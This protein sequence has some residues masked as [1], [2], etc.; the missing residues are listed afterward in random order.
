M[1]VEVKTSGAS[2]RIVHRV[3][4][5]YIDLSPSLGL[6]VAMSIFGIVGLESI[7]LVDYSKHCLCLERQ[8]VT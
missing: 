6:S 8:H 1:F 3:A 4:F 5:I 7:E 2:T